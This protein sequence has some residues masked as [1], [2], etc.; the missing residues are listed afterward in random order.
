MDL[1]R[2]VAKTQAYGGYFHYPMS[3][4]EIFFW[5]ISPR[6]IEYKRLKKYLPSLN[7]I[8]Q[9]QKEKL[10]HLTLQKEKIACE[11]LKYIR[12]FPFIRLVA[13]TGSV[14]ANN[15]QT[16]DDLDLLIITE[17]HTLWLTRL[18]FLLLLSFKFNRRHPGDTPSNTK[19]AF[20]PN[21]WLD[22]CSLSVSP[23][24]RNLYTA[25]EVLQVKPLFDRGGTY[26]SFIKANRW[27][28]RFLANAYQQL[29]LNKAKVLQE[30][31]FFLILA[32]LNFIFFSLQYL[33]MLPK[34]TVEVVGLH[35]AYF[36][37]ND[38]S[39]TLD[40]HLKDNSL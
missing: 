19:N 32:P 24:R 25:H 27:T 5:L 3:P 22:T 26:L 13:I 37:K 15:S 7:P 11:I 29:S 14:A 39:V 17:S 34:K 4:E 10:L 33:Y 35:S 28:S 23:K 40:N 20:C 6:P 31:P 12:F 36:H 21:L 2:A 16:N 1:H 8:E 38:L 30:N 9:K 18:F